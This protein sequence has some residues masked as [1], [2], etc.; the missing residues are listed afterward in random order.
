VELSVCENG[1][2]IVDTTPRIGVVDIQ[3]FSTDGM[4]LFN[5][6]YRSPSYIPLVD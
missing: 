2:F 4:P 5:T 6:C 3:I 1:R